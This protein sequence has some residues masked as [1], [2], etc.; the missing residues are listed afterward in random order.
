MTIGAL[1][2][3][4]DDRLPDAVLTVGFRRS[5]TVCVLVFEGELHAGSIPVLQGH[6][7]RLGR[8]PLREVVF[9]LTGLSLLDEQGVH[10]LT[11]LCHYVQARGG[12]L[13]LV[14]VSPWLS[15][16]LSATPLAACMRTEGG[17]TR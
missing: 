6:M 12:T 9:D 8:T 17:R 14:G 11:G 3:S 13:R 5:G 2:G 10:V 7:D 16:T 1:A 15:D 4:Q